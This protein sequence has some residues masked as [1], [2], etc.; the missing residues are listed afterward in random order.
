MSW[1]VW[2]CMHIFL[3]SN[4]LVSYCQITTYP[5]LCNS[6]QQAPL[7]RFSHSFSGSGIWGRLSW[8]TPVQSPSQNCHKALE[9]SGEAVALYHSLSGI[10]VLPA[11]HCSA[12][13]ALVHPL[14]LTI[15][16][17]HGGALSGLSKIQGL[18]FSQ[19]QINWN[20]FTLYGLI[21]SQNQPAQKPAAQGRCLNSSP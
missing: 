13:S 12:F 3:S 19:Y 16:H 6:K 9:P 4:I 2:L 14:G 11:F 18:F 17:I 1:S 8:M 7:C 20:L 10:T 5:K 21:S 15:T